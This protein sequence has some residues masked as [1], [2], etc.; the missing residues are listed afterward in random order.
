MSSMVRLTMFSSLGGKE[1]LS[2]I[3][4]MSFSTVKT[5]GILSVAFYPNLCKVLQ[6]YMSQNCSK[7]CKWF[8]A[9][10]IKRKQ[11]VILKIEIFD[12]TTQAGHF[13]TRNW[14]KTLGSTDSF[15]FF[16]HT[17]KPFLSSQMMRSIA[18]ITMP[19]YFFDFEEQVWHIKMTTFSSTKAK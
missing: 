5:N 9:Q 17:T 15:P 7:C 12:H 16:N 13:E 11:T 2:Q 4:M 3:K 19:S 14:T 10:V 8:N 1:Q 18:W 6:F